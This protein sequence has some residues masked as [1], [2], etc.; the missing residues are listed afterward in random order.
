MQ[1]S[2]R[3]FAIG[4]ILPAAMLLAA[5][6][7]DH[8]HDAA[9]EELP[10]PAVTT[11]DQ[12]RPVD[13]V[14]S[15]NILGDIAQQLVSCAGDGT[16]TVLMPAGADPHDFTPSSAQVAQIVEADLVFV[17]GLQLESGLDAALDGARTDGARIY[18]VAPR[19]DPIPFRAT[20][21]GHDHGKKDDHD[22]HDDHDHGKKDD[23]DDH[24]DHDHG[25][26]DDHDGHDH[27]DMD[28]HVWF[29]MSRMATA[30]T[31]MANEL[32]IVTGDADGFASCGTQVAEEI[33]SAEA[34]VRAALEA[35]P[36]DQRV[37]V[38]DHEALGYLA[39]VYG[40]EIAGTVIPAGTTLAQPSS[41]DLASLTKLLQDEGVTVIF[42]NVAEPTKLSDAIAAEVGGDVQVVPLFV[43][44]LG[45]PGSGA[46]TYISMM[47]TNAELISSSLRN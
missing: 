28:P 7:G 17:N 5:C 8:D 14:V 36:T 2:F 3:G 26:K 29:D 33:Q 45:A 25:K 46:D 40:Y 4:A 10:P 16:V 43:E 44:S 18:E 39:D 11:S 23:H 21:S 13:V 37:L 20:G 6:G 24:D 31:L 15:T 38:T 9:P 27:G 47:T 42:A 12:G 22:D 34:T 41:A 1:R 30:A 32:G 19:L 35:V